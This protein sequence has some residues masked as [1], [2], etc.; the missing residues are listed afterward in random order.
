M[1]RRIWFFL[2]GVAWVGF[3][4]SDAATVAVRFSSV[5]IVLSSFAFFT[6]VAIA[7][8]AIIGGLA[9]S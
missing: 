9:D 5:V 2:C 3:D 6:S 7:A 1:A 8:A 4:R